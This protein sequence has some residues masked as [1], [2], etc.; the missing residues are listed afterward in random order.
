M[1]MTDEQ[2]M[3]RYKEAGDVSAF[4]VLYD[5]YTPELIGY[6][7][8]L[9]YGQKNKADAEDVVQQTWRTVIEQSPNYQPNASFRTYLYIIL[10][11]RITDFYRLQDAKKRKHE[12]LTCE[13]LKDQ[14]SFVEIE[15]QQEGVYCTGAG[16]DMEMDYFYK[17]I[18]CHLDE[19]IRS[20]PDEQ[21]MVVLLYYY[22][23]FGVSEISQIMNLPLEN[24]KSKIR[25]A[26]KKIISE[27]AAIGVDV[28]SIFECL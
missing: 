5:K 19:I 16:G 14:E 13:I 6:T 28:D 27:L 25:S 12:V 11:S 8:N 20:M 10:K 1:S 18:Q 21:R 9:L 7:H 3:L 26:K 4:E 2:Y 15:T 24:I 22:Q 17:S 23:E